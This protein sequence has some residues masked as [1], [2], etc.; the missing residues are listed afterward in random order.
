MTPAQRHALQ[1][2]RTQGQVTEFGL[3]RTRAYQHRTLEALATAGHIHAHTVQGRIRP[4]R[5]WT[6]PDHTQQRIDG[7][8]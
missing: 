4:Y 8:A 6:H 5:I 3:R 1:W 7:A 2:L